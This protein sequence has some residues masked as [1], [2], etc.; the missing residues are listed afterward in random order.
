[1]STKAK[2]ERP[3]DNDITIVPK[4]KQT[5]TLLDLEFARI[6][7]KKEKVL[8][9]VPDA[10]NLYFIETNTEIE[11]QTRTVHDRYM[12]QRTEEKDIL[13]VRSLNH[14]G[15][16]CLIV[17]WD[18]KDGIHAQYLAQLLRFASSASSAS[19]LLNT[20]SK[21]LPT[22]ALFFIRQGAK[23]PESEHNGGAVWKIISSPHDNSQSTNG[24]NKAKLVPRFVETK[25]KYYNNLYGDLYSKT[26]TLMGFDRNSSTITLPKGKVLPTLMEWNAKVQYEVAGKI[27]QQPKDWANLSTGGDE[28]GVA[29][30]DDDDHEFASMADIESQVSNPCALNSSPTR[31]N[32]FDT[33]TH[34]SVSTLPQTSTTSNNKKGRYM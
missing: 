27:L 28:D 25:D 22:I 19:I 15:K 24:G 33:P 4:E 10:N 2:R 20:F 32:S 11:I 13:S 1:M 18:R 34:S 29:G 7:V 5:S 8:L 3:I 26:I 12:P 17:A 30:E 14:E 6:P 21:H 31:T 9:S 23:T 16:L